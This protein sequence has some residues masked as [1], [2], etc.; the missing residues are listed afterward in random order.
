MHWLRKL[1]R[2]IGVEPVSCQRCESTDFGKQYRVHGSD[3]Y[4][5]RTCG[6]RHYD[7]RDGWVVRDHED[8]TERFVS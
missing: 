7:G 2:K 3:H 1:V 5:C 8:I 4:R 6:A